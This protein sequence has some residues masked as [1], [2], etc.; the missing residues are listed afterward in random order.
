MILDGQVTL[1]ESVQQLLPAG[2]HVPNREGRAI[3]LVDL[4]THSIGLAAIAR[5]CFTPANQDNPY[6]DF[7]ATQLSAALAATRLERLPGARFTKYSNFGAGLLATHSRPKLGISYERARSSNPC[8]NRSGLHDTRINL[9]RRTNAIA[10][11]AG[12]PG[13]T[14]SLRHPWT[15]DALAGARSASLHVGG[16]RAIRSPESRSQRHSCRKPS[17]WT[18]MCRARLGGHGAVALGWHV[19]D[20]GRLLFHNGGTFGFHASMLIDRGAD[21]AVVVLANGDQMPVDDFAMNL[22]PYSAAMS[23]SSL[24][25]HR[26]R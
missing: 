6:A 8:S 19:L 22:V 15:F 10:S 9:C 2:F 26:S 7:G 23:P 21:V 18:Y 14:D 3:T 24:H 12:P 1:D 5:P 16:P 17:H 25:R 4:A 13:R 11:R 20:H